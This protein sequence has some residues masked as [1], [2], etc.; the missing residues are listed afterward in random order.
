MLHARRQQPSRRPHSLCARNVALSGTGVLVSLPRI[1]DTEM[2]A[3]YSGHYGGQA[4]LA[5]PNNSRSL[6][7]AAD[8]GALGHR[9]G[10]GS[11]LHLVEIGCASSFVLYNLRDLAAD[12][13][14][15][16]ASNPIRITTSGRRTFAAV[17][18]T[19]R[20]VKT[21][22]AQPLHAGCAAAGQRRRVHLEPRAR[23]PADPWIGSPVVPS[24]ETRRPVHGAA[25][26]VLQTAAV[27]PPAESGSGGARRG[28]SHP[29]MAR[30]SPGARYPGMFHVT[31]YGSPGATRRRRAT[32]ASTALRSDA[33]TRRLRAD[34]ERAVR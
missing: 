4:N 11:G 29:G 21:R 34:R 18:A 28:R 3:L 17:H 24:A 12:G 27:A 1:T 6:G 26:A 15:L 10:G 2:S 7:Q 19:T 30:L 33:P 14:S 13:G 20:G 25:H 23:A 9:S 8:I 31:L 16:R 22:R 5:G 32:H